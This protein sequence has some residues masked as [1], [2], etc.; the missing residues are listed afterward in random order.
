[1]DGLP[2]Y[3]LHKG[4]SQH[5]LRAY[6]QGLKHFMAWYKHVYQADFEPNLVMPRDIRFPAIPAIAYCRTVF[7]TPNV[8]STPHRL[9]KDLQYQC[10]QLTT[11]VLNTHLALDPAFNPLV[12]A[13][14]PDLIIVD[15]TNRLRTL[16]L[17]QVRDIY[18]RKTIGLVLIG[19][20]GL[21]K[22]LSRYPQLYSRIG[23]VHQFNALSLEEMGLVL[24]H[25]WKPLGIRF[26]LASSNQ[27][28]T[29]AAIYRFTGGN[30]RVIEHLY[31]QIDRIL[32]INNLDTITKEVVETARQSL[33]I[34]TTH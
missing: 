28:E 17:E 27:K 13:Y 25:M 30:F 19:M 32:R 24:S 20:P 8:A 11:L 18:D 1:V 21:E 29:L 10:N 5:T 2:D 12:N 4:K 16:G 14:E 23:F 15:E 26:D 34:G 33:L 6:R 7:F 9:A 3:L 31:A 22:S